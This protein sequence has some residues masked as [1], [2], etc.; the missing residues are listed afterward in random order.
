M[1]QKQ[2]KK[3]IIYKKAEQAEVKATWFIPFSR[4]LKQGGPQKKRKQKKVEQFRESGRGTCQEARP[5]FPGS[6]HNSYV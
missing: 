6:L 5:R 1:H 4:F 3:N 2:Q